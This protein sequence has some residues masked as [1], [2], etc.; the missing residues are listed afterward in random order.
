MTDKFI[1]HELDPRGC[2][3]CECENFRI[4]YAPHVDETALIKDEKYFILQGDFTE[5]YGKIRHLGF[6]ECFKFFE[7]KEEFKGLWSD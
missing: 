1:K 7:S 4:N 6:D 2:K 3:Y 5:E